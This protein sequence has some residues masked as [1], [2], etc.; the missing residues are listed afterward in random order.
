[1]IP[2]LLL[3]FNFGCVTPP[4]QSEAK[5]SSSGSLFSTQQQAFSF[6]T[7]S[8]LKRKLNSALNFSN[9]FQLMQ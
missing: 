1:M 4:A 2:A 7:F 8:L 9:A 6:C 3:L 5:C